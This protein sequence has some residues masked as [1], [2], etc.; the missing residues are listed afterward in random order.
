[1]MGQGLKRKSKAAS[2]IPSS[3]LADMAFL[4]LIFFMV[5]TT[6]PK[7]K[8]QEAVFPDAE[9]TQKLEQPRRDI[10]HVYILQNGTIFINDQNIAINDVSNVIA[11][12]YLENRGLVVMLRADREVAYSTIDQLLSEAQQAG[13]VRVSFYTNLEQRYSG[14]RR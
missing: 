14:E 8:K 10:L 11:P 6:F 9:A 1:M 7:E 2:D 4:L 3:S 5:T 12:L 13:A